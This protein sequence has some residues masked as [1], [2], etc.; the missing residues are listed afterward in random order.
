MLI[1]LTA[2][3]FRIPLFKIF[4][5]RDSN[6]KKQRFWE[7]KA[8]KEISSVHDAFCRLLVKHGTRNLVLAV[9][10]ECFHPLKCDRATVDSCP[11]PISMTP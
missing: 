5:L 3:N 7:K 1:H 2:N 9:T 6:I 10:A 8:C 4:F 11:F